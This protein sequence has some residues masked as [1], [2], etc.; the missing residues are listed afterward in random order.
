MEDYVKIEDDDVIDAYLD[1][2][3]YGEIL[4]PE[5]L[6]EGE[7]PPIYDDAAALHY[8]ASAIPK[9][10]KFTFPSS[11]PRDVDS[12]RSRV[13]R[14]IELLDNLPE[15]NIPLTAETGGGTTEQFIDK[16]SERYEKGK[17]FINPEYQNKDGATYSKAKGFTRGYT[18]TR[19]I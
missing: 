17:E 13:V 9:F 12:V 8:V 6:G 15:G 10:G 11:A 16:V 5:D 3:T 7:S 1:L 2:A 14:V 4:R 18:G 19:R